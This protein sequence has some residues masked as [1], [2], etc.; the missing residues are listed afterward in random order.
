MRLP[1]GLSL[2][3]DFLPVCIFV[4]QYTVY[5]KHAQKSSG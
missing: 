3:T 1:N 2:I 5:V 4:L